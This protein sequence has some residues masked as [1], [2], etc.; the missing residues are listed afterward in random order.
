[1]FHVCH[2]IPFPKELPQS[3]VV[4]PL[5]VSGTWDKHSVLGELNKVRQLDPN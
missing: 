5:T 1:M 4:M 2:L 3:R